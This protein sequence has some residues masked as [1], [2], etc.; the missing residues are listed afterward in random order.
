[1]VAATHEFAWAFV[2]ATTFL[3]AGIAGYIFWLGRIEPIPEPITTA[4]IPG[5]ST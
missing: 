4:R 1:V 3:L 5:P 2:V